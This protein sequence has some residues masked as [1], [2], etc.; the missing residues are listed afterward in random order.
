MTMIINHLRGLSAST[1]KRTIAIALCL[2]AMAALA[3]CGSQTD[4]S[5]VPGFTSVTIAM[6]GRSLSA[7][8]HAEAIPAF[9]NSIRFTVSAEGSELLVHNEDVA[10]L[11]SVSVTLEVP[12]GAAR[13]FLVEAIGP[14]GAVIYSGTETAD[15][16]GLPVTISIQMQLTM[17]STE[18]AVYTLQASIKEFG[19]TV[20]AKGALLTAA[21]LLPFYDTAYLESGM[22]RNARV[23]KD[24]A[25]LPYMSFTSIS[26]ANVVSYDS[27]NGIMDVQ[28]TVDGFMG[29]FP[30]TFVEQEMFRLDTATGKWRFYGNQRIGE[31]EVLFGTR[32]VMNG[33][34]VNDVTIYHPHARA[35]QGVVTSAT[36]NG[37]AVPPVIFDMVCGSENIAGMIFDNLCSSAAPG[38]APAVAAPQPGDV[39]N[40]TVTKSAGGTVTYQQTL[41]TVLLDAATIT[42]PTTYSLVDA[43]I[44]GT[45]NLT[46]T[47][48]AWAMSG[49]DNVMIQ[50]AVCD[51]SNSTSMVNGVAT[52][53]TSG[54]IA[55]PSLGGAEV[56]ANVDVRIH[57]EPDVF[58]HTL[59]Q[60]GA[61]CPF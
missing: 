60:F 10:G 42:S 37:P 39:Y 16:L 29:G 9:V 19:D 53:T 34:G 56:G 43:N 54:S 38:D 14:D 15:L 13:E 8:R 40:F 50:G 47:V 11:S 25:E 27:A 41:T 12:D 20:N 48:P 31:F 44:G 4:S 6:G 51:I 33:A 59:Y 46:W 18:Y 5:A 26:V 52:S 2:M 36:M 45:L 55:L 24:I 35:P 17:T 22:D 61:G 28:F 1:I 21:D 30:F 23:Q 7:D 57:Y 49:M 3:S 32:R 58:T